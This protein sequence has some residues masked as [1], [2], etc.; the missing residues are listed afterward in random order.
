M[1][2]LPE[3]PSA[4]A[5]AK[6]A[7]HDPQL[8]DAIGSFYS[9]IGEFP[10][11]LD[12]YSNA[13]ARD[14]AQPIYWFNRATV[15]RFLGR[16]SDAEDDYDRAIALR[17]NDYEAY[18]NRSELRKQTPDRNHIDAMERQ[19]ATNITNWRGEVQLRHALA[20]AHRPNRF[21]RRG[22]RSDRPDRRHRSQPQRRNTPY[23]GDDR[24]GFR[25]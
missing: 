17:P 5:A 4:S 11:A 2:S 10:R 24:S 20:K 18:T 14:P 6:A 22:G 3:A 21:G 8:L 7:A 25:G 15:Q 16:L 1:K 9:S 19:L 13:L 23:A 12:A